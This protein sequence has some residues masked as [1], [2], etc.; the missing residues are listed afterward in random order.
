MGDETRTIDTLRGNWLSLSGPWRLPAWPQR[1]SYGDPSDDHCHAIPLSDGHHIVFTDE[2]TG[3]LCL[4]ADQPIGSARKLSRKFV[5]EPPR[6]LWSYEQRPPATTVHA[7]AHNLDNGARIVAVYGDAIVLFSVP[8]DAFHYSTAEQEETLLAIRDPLED[9]ETA[10]ALLDPASNTSA[11]LETLPDG[12]GG[13]VIHKL[14]M[15]WVYWAYD[16]RE[17]PGDHS[18]HSIWPLRVY[19]EFMCIV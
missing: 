11:V 19:G 7:A 13:S 10:D 1:R 18:N 3:I 12:Q 17:H 16:F 15:A 2:E 8:I 6:S 5:L 9:L 4:G 14:N